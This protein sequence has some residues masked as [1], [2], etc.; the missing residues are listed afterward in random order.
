M[1]LRVVG[2]GLG[3]TG[4]LSLKSA[5]ER[6]LGAPCH[7][8]MEVFTHPEQVEPITQA[9]KGQPTDWKNLLA[10]YSATVDWPLA[11]CWP[12]LS[13]AF[14]KAIVL[15]STRDSAET[16]WESANATMF[17]GIESAPPSKWKDMVEAMFG[18]RFT[19]RIDDRASAIA[20]YEKHNA[21]VR[22][23]VP[24]SRLVEYQPGDGW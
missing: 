23:T 7:H 16:W 21:R 4:T 17:R 6:L 10:G 18:E 22:A 5:L 24:K 15:L 2:A 12:E 19:R 1:T 9:L 20:S 8:M 3:R 14:P 11:A 13:E